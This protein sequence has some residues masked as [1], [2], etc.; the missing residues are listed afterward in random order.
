MFTLKLYQ[1]TPTPSGR[2]AVMEC[3]GIWVTATDN[4]VKEVYVFKDKVGVADEGN[5]TTQFFVG[6]EPGPDQDAISKGIGGNWYDWGV[7]ENAQ[8]KAI[9]H[10]R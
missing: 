2:V 8:G 6:G 4:G 1:N 10:L 7:L 5:R 3:A 9:M